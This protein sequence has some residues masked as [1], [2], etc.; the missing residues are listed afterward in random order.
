MESDQRSRLQKKIIR[1]NIVFAPLE[2]RWTRA[3]KG[4]A[5]MSTKSL[6]AILCV[7]EKA[8]QKIVIVVAGHMKFFKNRPLFFK[9]NLDSPLI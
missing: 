3:F 8:K 6:V 5:D 2:I 9:K 1:E 4:F 7:Y